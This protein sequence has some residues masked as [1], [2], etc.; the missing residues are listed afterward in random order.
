MANKFMAMF[1][2]IMVG[3]IIAI[4]F[5]SEIGNNVEEQTG[6]SNVANESG[7]L[8]RNDSTGTV[9]STAVLTVSIFP[10]STTA[11]NLSLISF[12]LG[13]S[14]GDLAALTTDYTIDLASGQYS[15]INSSF[16]LTQNQSDNNTLITYAY[17]DQD[18]IQD[19]SSRSIIR[20]IL[21]FGSIAIFIFV[22]VIIFKDSSVNDKLKNLVGSK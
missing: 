12:T 19:A 1:I 3:S 11:S 7:I 20:L 5:L 2:I 4:S 17:R 14:S 8:P 10:G 9:N 22:I 6:Q 18:Y 15:L 13:N 16:W 21:I